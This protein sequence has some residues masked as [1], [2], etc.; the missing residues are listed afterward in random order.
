MFIYHLL[1]IVISWSTL[2]LVTE[3]ADVLQ[4]AIDAAQARARVGQQSG[5]LCSLSSH[6]KRTNFFLLW[7]LQNDQFGQMAYSLIESV[8]FHHPAANVVVVSV[9]LPTNMFDSYLLEGYCVVSVPLDLQKAEHLLTSTL[10]GHAALAFLQKAGELN[11]EGSLLFFL[12]CM[13]LAF[14]LIYGGVSLSMDGLLLNPFDFMLPQQLSLVHTAIFLER[15]LPTDGKPSPVALHADDFDRSWLPRAYTDRA[16]GY[17]LLCLEAICP[18]SLPAKSSFGKA[19]LQQWISNFPTSKEGRPADIPDLSQFATALYRMYV[20]HKDNLPAQVE[21]FKFEHHVALLPYWVTVEPHFP[22]GWK[23]HGGHDDLNGLHTQLFSPR[24]QR[25]PS[26]WSFIAS[27]KLWL[28][29]GYGPPSARNILPRSV[30]DLAL[31]FFTLGIMPQPY[32]EKGFGRVQKPTHGHRLRSP[33]DALALFGSETLL[34]QHEGMLPGN[35]GGFRAFRQIRLVG[36]G[37]GTSTRFW[38]VTVSAERPDLQFFCRHEQR[39][40]LNVSDA[41]GLGGGIALHMCRA[42]LHE[43][44]S[45]IPTLTGFGAGSSWAVKFDA[46]G[47]PGEVNSA[48]T[49]LAYLPIAGLGKDLNASTISEVSDLRVNS[50]ELD[51]HFAGIQIKAMPSCD[52]GDGP[53]DSVKV[54]ALLDDVQDQITVL[55]HCAERC[56]LLDRLA[57]SFRKAYDR[58]PVIATCEC[59][60]EEHCTEPIVR[61]NENISHMKVVS[62]PYDFGLSRG[63]SLLAKMATTEFVLVLDD[64]FVHSYH[65]CLEC[66]LWHMRSRY[67]SLWRPF[68][69]LGFPVVEDERLFGAFRGQL[70]VT[71][72]QLFLEPMVEQTM[73]DGC[74]RVDICPMVFLARTERF[75][76][77][78]FQEDLRV[79]EHEQFFYSNAYFGLQVAVCMDS[80]FPH[81]RVNTMSAGYTKR[82]ERM[83]QLMQSAFKKLGFQRAMYLFRKYDHGSMKDYDE[84][85]DKTTPPWFISDDTCG[86]RTLPPAPF[87]QVFAVI[88]S[89]ADSKGGQYRRILRGHTGAAGAWLRRCAEFGPSNFRWMFAVAVQEEMGATEEILREQNQHHDLI[90]LPPTS[91]YA[92]LSDE[93]STDQLLR[94]LASLRDFQFRWLVITRQ[95]VFVNFNSFLAALTGHDPPDGKVLGSWST[96]RNIPF[97]MAS[98]QHNGG[99]SGESVS[100]RLDTRFFVLARDVF[101]LMSSAE[102]SSRL[103]SGGVDDFFG[104]VS[105]FGGGLNTWLNSLAIHR[106]SL[107]GIM[108]GNGDTGASCPANAIAFHPVSPE[109]LHELSYAYGVAAKQ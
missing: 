44:Q 68:D 87:S 100:L 90:L 14:Q 2:H 36:Q 54:S 83:Q 97:K 10:P 101:T 85:L 69:I 77:F 22:D 42:G 6:D 9:G 108:L 41:A 57:I 81:F 72:H 23:A 67:H 26:D 50:D 76:S 63:K 58:L 27:S 37:G 34:S 59:A 43:A 65:S 49:L 31:R 18:R 8:L 19:L 15:L 16:D 103:N 30:T 52:K 21:D 92:T 66:M 99:L 79:G 24:P 28:P 104:D 25:E 94:V 17:T 20:Q 109:Q 105:A 91:T 3:G 71:G 78:K 86:P 29:L 95:D 84:L 102:L 13:M 82:R 38:R 12:N 5:G 70:R 89:S 107:S 60:E 11:D 33:Q 51:M 74:L 62:V 93:P 56:F 48:L 46:C 1:G 35:V 39:P 96:T 75:R 40:N 64:D 32:K 80:S 73:L 98:S 106:I 47:L 61:P 7:P 55:A 53:I 4:T 45:S 88:L